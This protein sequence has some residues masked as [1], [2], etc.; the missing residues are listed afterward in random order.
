MQRVENILKSVAVWNIYLAIFH[1]GVGIFCILTV[2]Q[3]IVISKVTISVKIG[4]K[5][6]RENCEIKF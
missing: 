6:E 5:N 3:I 4:Q 1:F 2:K